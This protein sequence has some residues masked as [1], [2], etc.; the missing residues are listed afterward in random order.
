MGGSTQ[1]LIE[2]HSFRF[3]FYLSRE[4]D[5]QRQ[6]LLRKLG[7][8]CFHKPTYS[9]LGDVVCQGQVRLC[10]SDENGLSDHIFKLNRAKASEQNSGGEGGQG[11]LVPHIKHTRAHLSSLRLHLTNAHCRIF[12]AWCCHSTL[13]CYSK[14]IRDRTM[15]LF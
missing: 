7:R 5:R 10:V 11:H 9:F 2:P 3:R 14:G 1:P 12:L 13:Y 8:G 6:K 4:Q 15:C